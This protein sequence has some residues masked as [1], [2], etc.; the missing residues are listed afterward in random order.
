MKIRAVIVDD[1]L[2]ARKKIR[3]LLKNETRIDIVGE[4]GSG[5]A[6]I[7]EIL[8]AKPDL[9]FLDIQMPGMTG[10]EVLEALGADRP[11]VIFATAFDQYAI[12]AFD[13]RALDY[14]LKPIDPARFQRAVERAL[15]RAAQ[16]AAADPRI[17]ELLA[18]LRRKQ[19]FL[20]RILLREEGRISFIETR[21][22]QWIEAEEKYIRIHMDGG[23]CLYRET[24]NNLEERLDPALFSRVHR[25][26]IVNME[27][28][29]EVQ[30]V[31]HGDHALVLGDGTRLPLGRNYRDQFFQRFESR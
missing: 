26:Y 20:R 18:E 15:E 10:F 31:S 25:S 30:S 14:L 8:A 6:A 22:I 4:A 28:V 2:P 7:R 16:P 27:Q 13:V 5:E 21:R 23:A 1:E 17:D 11:Q 24:M 19:P 9:V 29:R 12:R 3:Q